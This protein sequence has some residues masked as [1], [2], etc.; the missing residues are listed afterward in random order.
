MDRNTFTRNA[1]CSFDGMPDTLTARLSE[2][3]SQPELS[4]MWESERTTFTA[5]T[6]DGNQTSVTAPELVLTAQGNEATLSFP[7]GGNDPEHRRLKEAFERAVHRYRPDV[8]LEW[9]EKT[10]MAG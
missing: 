8:K 6:G 5:G 9:K 10:R 2:A 4:R 1:N 7:S 3:I